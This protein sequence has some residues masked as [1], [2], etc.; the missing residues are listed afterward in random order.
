MLW[1]TRRVKKIAILIA[2]AFLAYG[3]IRDQGFSGP[4]SS[5]SVGSNAVLEEALANKQSDIQ[6]Q[7]SGKVLKVLRDDLE[8]SR[9][10]KFIVQ[11]S[12]G[13]T[14]LIS[15]NIDLAPR[16]GGLAAGDS[17]EFFGEYEWNA[18]GGVIHWTHDDP[19][20]RHIDGWLKHRG[21]T[22]R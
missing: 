21:R 4:S 10:Q 18:K 14:V 12:N 22:Y 16:V 3:Y 5:P 6:V 13:Q 2:L 15:H 17:V 20:H 7:G 9:H 8:G 11:L 1:Q 19:N